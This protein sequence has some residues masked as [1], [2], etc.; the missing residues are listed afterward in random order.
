LTIAEIE[1]RYPTE[2]VLLD[3]LVVDEFK[4]VQAGRVI[5]HSKNRDDVYNKMG[6]YSGGEFAVHFTGPLCA[7]YAL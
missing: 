6:T 5:F 2:W 3:D 1:A 7:L 4:G